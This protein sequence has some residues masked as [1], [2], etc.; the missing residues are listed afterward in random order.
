MDR[1]SA[2]HPLLV[3]PVFV[4]PVLVSNERGPRVESRKRALFGIGRKKL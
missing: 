1:S 2:G 4:S 3:S